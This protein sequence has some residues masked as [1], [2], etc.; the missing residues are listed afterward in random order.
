MR[1]CIDYFSFFGT[2]FVSSGIMLI[3]MN[4]DLLDAF[5]S[6]SDYPY[7][8]Y[9]IGFY[10][11]LGLDYIKGYINSGLKNCIKNLCFVVIF[12]QRGCVAK[13]KTFS[14]VISNNIKFIWI[15]YKL[16]STYMFW[17]LFSCVM[18]SLFFTLIHHCPCYLYGPSMMF[19]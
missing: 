17:I 18:N 2:S 8:L 14:H 12:Y 15:I 6:I 3:I 1:I 7:S 10:L 11:F 16:R 13:S 19:I 9:L 4:K 5:L